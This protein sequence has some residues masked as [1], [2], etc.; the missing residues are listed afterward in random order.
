MIH[1]LIVL[2]KDNEHLDFIKYFKRLVTQWVWRASCG[3]MC[4]RNPVHVTHVQ[5][6]EA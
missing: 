2:F 5:L 1:R 3:R 6:V 4:D